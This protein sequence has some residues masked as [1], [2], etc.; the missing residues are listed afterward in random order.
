VCVGDSDPANCGQCNQACVQGEACDTGTCKCEGSTICP[1]Q[2]NPSYPAS[3]TTPDSGDD[4]TNCGACG[5][6]C[7]DTQICEAGTCKCRPNLDPCGG[8]CVDLQSDG[9]NCGACGTTCTV[10]TLCVSGKCK[11][12]VMGASVGCPVGYHECDN[13]TSCVLVFDGNPINCGGCGV[14]CAV[15]QVC[16]IE[17]QCADYFVPPSACDGCGAGTTC[18]TMSGVKVCV[19]G[20]VCGPP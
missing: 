8:T 1:A 16:T 9:A 13:D 11:S 4:P 19:V 5:N 2:S 12:A 3:C 7:K 18:C 6:V 10:G 17:G 15:D 20:S 14:V